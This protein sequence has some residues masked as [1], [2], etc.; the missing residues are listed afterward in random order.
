MNWD[1]GCRHLQFDGCKDNAYVMNYTQALIHLKDCKYNSVKCPFGCLEE[2]LL[3]DLEKHKSD[4][5][6]STF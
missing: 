2:I 5:D 1:N 4:C 6:H 3:L